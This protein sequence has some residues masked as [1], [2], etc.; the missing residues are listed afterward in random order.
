MI[1]F[2]C[3]SHCLELL[4]KGALNGTLFGLIDEFLLQ[5]YYINEKL[6]K[7]RIRRNSR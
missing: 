6:L 7:Y 2:W 3:L 1:S 5:V 4:I